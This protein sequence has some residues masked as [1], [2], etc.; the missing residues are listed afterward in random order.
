MIFHIEQWS[1]GRPWSRSGLGSGSL[2]WLTSK[3]DLQS[4]SLIFHDETGSTGGGT[5]TLVAIVDDD[6]AVRETDHSVLEWWRSLPAGTQAQLIQHGPLDLSTSLISDLMDGGHSLSKTW[7]P[8]FESAPPLGLAEELAD[9]VDLIRGA[10][11]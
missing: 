6:R 1:N 9:F 8:D 7:L 5:G 2:E 10:R 11:A 4:N 3:Q